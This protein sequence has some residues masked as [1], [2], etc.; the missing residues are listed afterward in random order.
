MTNNVTNNA[1]EVGAHLTHIRE[2]AGFTQNEL[3]ERSALS[4]DVLSRIESG[5][6]SVSEEELGS[7]LGTIGTEEARIFKETLGRHWSYL[8]QPAPGHPDEGVLWQAEL[9]LQEVKGL[10]ESPE[11]KSVLAKQLEEFGSE[12]EEAAKSV[13][14]IDHRI[15]FVGENGV[16]KSRALCRIAG[17]EIRGGNNPAP[18]LEVGAGGTTVCEVHILRANTYGF[19]VEPMGADELRREVMEFAIYLTGNIANDPE[20]VVGERDAQG[21]SREIERV[22]RNMS[23]LTASRRRLSDGRRERIDQARD[24]AGESNDAN[25]LA[26]KIMARIG[27]SQRDER[28]LSYP[29]STDKEP[30]L[31]LKETFEQLNRGQHPNFSLPKRID[32]MIPGHILG[33]EELSICLVDTKGID[34]AGGR[35]DLDAHFNDSNTVVVLCSQFN[36]APATELQQ[37]LQLAA[38]SGVANL[39]IK[40]AILALPRPGEAM[41]VKDDQGQTADSVLDGYDLKSEQAEMLLDSK[42]LPYAGIEFFNAS[43]DDPQKTIAFLLDLV[44]GVRQQHRDKLAEVTR[45]ATALISNFAAAEL[46]AVNRQAARPLLR[47]LQSN[48]ELPN[49][50]GSLDA[51]LIHAIKSVYPSTVRASIRRQ[52][53]WYNLNYSYQLGYSARVMAVRCVVPLR[54]KF[55]ERAD[56][57]R[58]DGELKPAFGLIDQAVRILQNGVETL[59]TQSELLGQT[60]YNQRLKPDSDFWQQ[61]DGEWGQGP[62][63]RDRVV[64]HHTVWLSDNGRDFPAMVQALIQREWQQ[65]LDRVESILDLET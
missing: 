11:I 44:A 38:D 8:Q 59:L 4:P 37:Q 17:L 34:S 35:A 31:W 45:G 13:L 1:I 24:L 12:L 5:E 47:W 28:Q 33:N 49:V 39:G 10:V 54:D 65:I 9:A 42:N 27:L 29:Q 36:N 30:L 22:I 20:Q 58:E 51:T 2:K 41:A 6:Q 14:N 63:Y 52:G 43:E 40:T 15:V 64:Q 50:R 57:I 23:G 56:V 61:C 48:R 7:I 3:A 53:D 25:A 46:Q 26:E 18:V 21:T 55:K 32:I 16:G 62:G 19:Y 60:I